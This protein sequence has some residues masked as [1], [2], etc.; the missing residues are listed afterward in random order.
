M[1]RYEQF[2]IQGRILRNKTNIPIK[3]LLVRAFDVDYLT[4]DDFLGEAH[5]DAQGKFTITYRESDFVKNI[6]EAFFEGGP[7]IVLYIYAPDGSL[8]H[9]TPKRSG[10]HRFEQFTIRIQYSPDLHLPV[11]MAGKIPV[12]E[13]ISNV[14][15]IKALQRSGI[16]SVAQLRD[17]AVDEVADLPF[18][19][20]ADI[21]RDVLTELKSIAFLSTVT[22]DIDMARTLVKS[23]V[24]SVRYLSR[25][26][27]EELE[28]MINNALAGGLIKDADRPS[29]NMINRLIGKA[30]ILAGWLRRDRLYELVS[31]GDNSCVTCDE[32]C[33]G[34][35]S[36]ILSKSA[37][38]AYLV[39]KTGEDVE[40]L[41]ARFHQNFMTPDCRPLQLLRIAA[42]VLARALQNGDFGAGKKL[43]ALRLLTAYHIVVRLGLLRFQKYLDS[44]GLASFREGELAIDPL[45][46]F[47]LDNESDLN[48]ANEKLLEHNQQLSNFFFDHTRQGRDMLESA[49]MQS[50]QAVLSAALTS[51]DGGWEEELRALGKDSALLV[52]N[53]ASC[54][55]NALI[56]LSGQDAS[57]LRHRYHVNFLAEEGMISPCEQAII[58][59]Q[60][61]MRCD[62]A[63]YL[64]CCRPGDENLIAGEKYTTRFKDYPQYRLWVEQQM[65]PENFYEQQL[66]AS[67]VHGNI[68][69]FHKQLSDA[70]AILETLTEQ[71]ADAQIKSVMGL[72]GE[73]L[74]L[75]DNL[76]K[77]DQLFIEGNQA[78]RD[79]EYGVALARFA[80]AQALIRRHVSQYH[81]ATLATC[82]QLFF[83]ASANCTGIRNLVTNASG[84][85]RRLEKAQLSPM[86]TRS[87]IPGDAQRYMNVEGWFPRMDEMPDQ[88]ELD[89]TLNALTDIARNPI[90]ALNALVQ[91]SQQTLLNRLFLQGSRQQQIYSGAMDGGWRIYDGPDGIRRSFPLIIRKN[92]DF[93]GAARE[94]ERATRKLLFALFREELRSQ[95]RLVIEAINAP[96]SA[97]INCLNNVNAP[98][99][100]DYLF[101]ISDF[102]EDTV[103]AL[104]IIAEIIARNL[105]NMDNIVNEIIAAFLPPRISPDVLDGEAFAL[106]NIPERLQSAVQTALEEIAGNI[107]GDISD[108]SVRINNDSDAAKTF[109]NA[110]VQALENSLLLADQSTWGSRDGVIE[111]LSNL[112][113][114]EDVRAGGVQRRGTMLVDKEG[115]EH[116]E[117]YRSYSAL[118]SFESGDN[119]DLGVVF[120]VSGDENNASSYYLLSLRNDAGENT[121]RDLARL[122]VLAGYPFAVLGL[123]AAAPGAASI[124]GALG[125]GTYVPVIGHIFG[126]AVGLVSGI[127]A[128]IA[129][130]TGGAFAL[131][132]VYAAYNF[133]E[134]SL[135]PEDE[136][137]HFGC[138]L[139]VQDGQVSKL[140]GDTDF[141]L[142]QHQRY[143]LRLDVNSED[144]GGVHIMARLFEGE[145]ENDAMQVLDFDVYEASGQAL[146][147]GGI[148]LYSFANS[149]SRF[150]QA[151]ISR[152]Q[153]NIQDVSPGKLFFLPGPEGEKYPVDWTAYE[154]RR[155]CSANMLA[156]CLQLHIDDARFVSVRGPEE[157]QALASDTVALVDLSV[158]GA[159]PLTL[160]WQPLERYVDRQQLARLTNQL[161]ALMPHYY[162]FLLPLAIGDTLHAMG[163][164]EQA[165]RHYD[166]CSDI[167]PNE[168]ER[169]ADDG[170]VYYADPKAGSGY[171][172]LHT[173]QPQLGILGIE[174]R[175]MRTRQAANEIAAGEAF[176]QEDDAASRQRAGEHFI[177]ALQAHGRTYCCNSWPGE[178]GCIP[179]AAP[180]PAPL[181]PERPEVVDIPPLT[182]MPEE[183]PQN[184]SACKTQYYRLQR[185]IAALAAEQRD[186]V[187]AEAENL[188]YTAIDQIEDCLTLNNIL[189]QLMLLLRQER[190]RAS[191]Q[192]AAA[193]R[194]QH[195]PAEWQQSV[196]VNAY[197]QKQH[198]DNNSK[199][200]NSSS[201]LWAGNYHN[202]S[203][204]NTD[205]PWIL[206]TK[207]NMA[208]TFPGI[209]AEIADDGQEKDVAV[210]LPCNERAELDILDDL[211]DTSA[212]GSCAPGNP[213]VRSQLL[214][215]CT[216]LQRLEL[217]LNLLGLR[218]NAANTYRYAYLI[219][220]ARHYAELAVNAEKN[221][222][223]FREKLVAGRLTAMQ[224]QY[225]LQTLGIQ[226]SIQSTVIRQAELQI[227]LAD[228]QIG[229]LRASDKHIEQLLLLNDVQMTLAVL[230]IGTGVAQ[231]AAGV[232]SGGATAVAAA[233]AAAAPATAGASLLAALPGLASAGSN[234][235]GIPGTVIGGLQG[236]MGIYQQK[237][238]LQQQRLQIREFDLPMAALT[239][240]NARLARQSAELQAELNHLEIVYAEGVASYN[241]G[242]LLSPQMYSF[243][244]RQMKRMY[245][246]YLAFAVQA[247]RMAEDALE[248]ERGRVF[249]IIQSD[250]YDVSLQGLLGGEI[251]AKDIETLEYQR[252]CRDERRQYPPAKVYSLLSSF[253]LA[254]QS[255][256]QSGNLWFRTQEIDFERDF[257]GHY[258]RQIRSVRVLLYALTGIEGVKA[259][260]AHLGPSEIVIQ[261]ADGYRSHILPGEAESFALAGSPDGRGM[262]A[263]NPVAEEQ[264]N[265][266]EGKGVTGGWL[267]E[268]PKYANAIDFASIADIMFIVEYESFY[269]DAYRRDV[270]NYLQHKV[271]RGARGLHVRANLP[272]AFYHLLNPGVTG[273]P[274]STSVA[275]NLVSL[276]IPLQRAVYPVNEV[277][278]ILD[279]LVL[280]LVDDNGESFVLDNIAISIAT[281]SH[282][283]A[284]W[285]AGQLIYEK[286][287]LTGSNEIWVERGGELVKVLL[288]EVKPGE[289]AD[290]GKWVR[291]L[292]EEQLLW[293][294]D[295]TR[296]DSDVL[297]SDVNFDT[298]R[299]VPA[300]LL[301]S[302]QT[303][304]QL[305]MATS[306]YG[307]LSEYY[308][309]CV[310]D[311]GISPGQ[312]QKRIIQDG[313]LIWVDNSATEPGLAEGEWLRCLKIAPGAAVRH[314]WTA[315][316]G[317]SDDEYCYSAE[318]VL[319]ISFDAGADARC[320]DVGQYRVPDLTG[321]T[322]IILMANYRYHLPIS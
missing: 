171:E 111:E 251:L 149:P 290:Q 129:I 156:D 79:E 150:F 41:S 190:T 65:F 140:A 181:R 246:H 110:V 75:I 287:A 96:I 135:F 221:F 93:Q 306:A 76:L 72:F 237:A 280:A 270:E 170:Q 213:L 275:L 89:N 273:N 179:G 43:P 85:M 104:Q 84:L 195:H 137:G 9:T 254:F 178:A 48:R 242:Q 4:Q 312:G 281:R 313:E 30:D 115:L 144:N 230:S 45:Q 66:K 100:G 105:S 223:Q 236:I 151:D 262:I 208:E 198:Q 121:S 225:T 260:L 265:P 187:L 180:E 217:N 92:A 16:W 7:D 322:E 101:C 253:P 207:G 314:E 272:D 168:I 113:N 14:K 64:V 157:E 245:K 71:G 95:L 23:G 5:T 196:L 21:G 8:L 189:E 28:A 155:V 267:L 134:D 321:L 62:Q 239:E 238:D 259:T 166:I 302:A 58:T 35:N 317:S 108:L 205:S 118:I 229:K 94:I 36:S 17:M 299:Q 141:Q 304:M 261:T 70:R 231:G 263:L 212:F 200:K 163:D 152:R 277:D 257:P 309:L 305:Q 175:L 112:Y 90:E 128:S 311:E 107:A 2:K 256:K 188:G 226:A 34:V 11:R 159:E 77:V 227:E 63:W 132:L 10:A 218:A 52:S 319:Y 133:A 294:P 160:A 193:N 203:S 288:D 145:Q 19:K 139:R 184:L 80:E 206:L 1:S 78:G 120:N 37:Y 25:L 191:A 199:S 300:E 210:P 316:P 173:E 228:C 264:L 97:A 232:V 255:F 303:V 174:E 194:E 29:M 204:S 67:L 220:L 291:V 54:L 143:V 74:Q 216:N 138:L 61:L 103:G 153:S 215:A 250:Y 59:L 318:D 165:K 222:I 42:E 276:Q 177:R 162:F 296:A 209:H 91:E 295:N 146:Q 86:L 33:C 240:E 158:F 87:L 131:P 247:A 258:Y 148:G 308:E 142:Q 20:A 98:N 289:L 57:A 60:E 315:M 83:G 233:A 56:E 31:C 197:E 106:D 252:L 169:Q 161:V 271:F 214:Q 298:V 201:G 278:R 147:P 266:F 68:N 3:D 268:V 292:R 6:L 269:D 310:R 119:D 274:L 293:I 82:E 127:N 176:Y 282:V 234:A 241:A 40:A 99:P 39:R 130:L 46:D 81:G 167:F 117:F 211:A 50:T 125:L 284:L 243:L 44:A 192:S 47:S 27:A 249:D 286:A 69:I 123:A 73:G 219:S 32:Q 109:F 116:P 285:K 164:Y 13:L 182:M 122:G 186:N 136:A 51:L 183:V 26:H 15:Q 172:F 224:W 297:A 244:A 53:I 24:K 22:Q 38:L 124:L 126:E 185:L 114:V 202:V 320:R 301:K 307:S 12:H 55:R 283:Q 102:V 18:V 154:Q 49:W 235:A 279:S 88:A 248:Y